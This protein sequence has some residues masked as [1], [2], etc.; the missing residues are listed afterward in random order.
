M[1]A[2]KARH[3]GAEKEAQEELPREA[4]H[5]DEAHERAGRGADRDLAEVGPIDLGLLAGQGAETQEGL[6]R[7]TRAV[8]RDDRAEVIGTALVAARLDHPVES[9]RAEARIL[10]ERLDD[11]RGVGIRHRGARLCRGGDGT[12]LEQDA[13]DRAVV[14][15]ELR[16][17]GANRPLLG[18]MKT[19]DL[20]LTLGPDLGVLRRRT[21]R[22]SPSPDRR[23]RDPWAAMWKV[24]SGLSPGQSSSPKRPEPAQGIELSAAESTTRIGC[25]HQ[26]A[27]PSS[28]VRSA[29]GC[30]GERGRRA[31]SR[32]PCSSS[33]IN[34]VTSLR[35][36]RSELV[37]TPIMGS[38]LLGLV[39]QRRRAGVASTAGNVEG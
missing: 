29:R 24:T 5:H 13:T 28:S 6:C 19:E 2:K 1:A 39:A 32:S 27:V 9:T 30:R 15:A 36:T 10:R 34:R 22:K 16:G 20:R 21:A 26:S 23:F 35:V 37:H 33:S 38:A 11:E 17:D 12:R 4:Q 18:V 7:G 25:P 31:L 14:V 3:R 8:A